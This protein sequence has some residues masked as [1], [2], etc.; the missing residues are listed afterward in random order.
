VTSANRLLQ[1]PIDRVIGRLRGLG[2]NPKESGAGQW[3]SKCPVHKGKNSN[4]SIKAGDDGTVIL[5]CHHVEQGGRTCSPESIVKAIGLEMKDLFPPK[6]G[7]T[8]KRSKAKAAKNGKVWRS[9]EDAIA[10][11]A[12]KSGGR[13]S[14]PW[15]YLDTDRS[16]LMRAYRID[17]PNDGKEFLPVH[18]DHAG[19]HIGDPPGKLPLYHLDK[20]A[21]ADTVFVLEGEKCADLVCNLG[22]VATTSS[23]GNASA[24]RSNWTPLAGKTVVMIPDHDEAGEKYIA[25]VG[26]A[27]SELDPKPVVKVLRLPLKNVGDDVEQWLETAPDTWGP[28]ECRAGLERLATDAPPWHPPPEPS[29]AV[30]PRAKILCAADVAPR[31][32]KWLW[33]Q[34]IAD[35]MLATLAGDPKLGKSFVTLDMSARVSRGACFPGSNLQRDPGSVILLSAEDDPSRIIIPRL[36]AAQADLK[37]IHILESVY[38]KNGR[39]AHPS[40]AADIETIEAE[41]ARLKDCRLIVIDPVTAYLGGIDD[42]RNSELRG[43]LS[44]LKAMAERLGIAIVLVTHLSKGGGTNGKH[45]VIGSIAYVGACRTNSLFI[46]DRTDPTNRRVLMCDNGNNLGAPAPTLGFVIESRSNGPA[47]EW[48]DGE[49][50]ITAEQALAAE[51][52]ALEDHKGA[53]ERRAAEVFLAELLKDGPVAYTIIQESAKHSGISL[54]TLRRA[55]QSLKVI[56]GKIGFA[57][58]TCWK[59]RLPDTPADLPNA[60]ME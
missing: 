39:E 19:W 30:A 31:E 40:L 7:P 52:E 49:I 26:K 18:P 50:D 2:F 36:I 14:D 53:P 37:K 57:K 58:G 20:L 3:K 9:P 28:E 15:I 56:A 8:P 12:G 51:A 6:D 33:E 23:H 45:R 1:S 21:A 24:G 22:I 38:L 10:F 13:A 34:R 32:V 41:A 5:H 25:D 4:L 43:A 59:W 54:I 27:L 17:L 60:L 46:R 55:K 44:P 47:V 42:H 29:E 11:V 16:E 35:G 48:V